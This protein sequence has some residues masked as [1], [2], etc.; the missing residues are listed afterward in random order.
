MRRGDANDHFVCELEDF[1]NGYADKE[2][3]S[4]P[5]LRAASSQ[6]GEVDRQDAEVSS[7]ETILLIRKRLE[8][9][10]HFRGRASQFQIEMIGGAIVLSGRL[11]T[12]YLKQ[13][14]QEAV[15]KIPDVAQI[16]NRVEVTFH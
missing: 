4:D 15:K 9:H 12:Y 16:D 11:P 5:M 1:G 2:S 10:P 7:N 3:T 6:S 13:L 14:L 8:Q